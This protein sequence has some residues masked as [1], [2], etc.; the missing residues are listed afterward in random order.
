MNARRMY[1]NIHFD[2]Y[3]NKKKTLFVKTQNLI[4]DLKLNA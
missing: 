4:L 1:L 3:K 2:M